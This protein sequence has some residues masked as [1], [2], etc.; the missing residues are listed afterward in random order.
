MKWKGKARCREPGLLTT[1]SP[2]H[3]M[4]SA[5]DTK[6]YMARLLSSQENQFNLSKRHTNNTHG[7]TIQ[8]ARTRFSILTST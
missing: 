7:S 4:L 8:V 6:I 3:T 2:T 5:R 1:I